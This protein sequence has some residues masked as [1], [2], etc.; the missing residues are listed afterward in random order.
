MSTYIVG[1]YWGPRPTTADAGVRQLVDWTGALVASGL[2]GVDQWLLRRPGKLK[3]FAAG[4]LTCHKDK[5]FRQMTHEITGEVT[6]EFGLSLAMYTAHGG[7]QASELT[8]RIGSLLANV[9]NSMVLTLRAPTATTVAT[10]EELMNRA[11]LIFDPEHAVV[12][13]V[14]RVD[15]LDNRLPWDRPSLA[16]YSRSAR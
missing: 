9:S 2:P 15:V 14:D 3:S 4:N 12:L 5:L 10:L 7:S 6:P 16:L 11:I 8:A 13:D 1:A